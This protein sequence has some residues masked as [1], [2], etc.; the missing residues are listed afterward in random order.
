MV[1]ASGRSPDPLRIGDHHGMSLRSVSMLF[2]VALLAFASSSC[3]D[4]GRL[5]DRQPDVTGVVAGTDQ[6]AGP[7]L[8]EPSDSYFERMSLVR[9]DPVLVKSSAGESVPFSELE[10]GDEVEVWIDGA[11]AESYP[12]Q[13]GIVALRL[14]D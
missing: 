8:T 11:C 14:R 5:P 9:G 12:V 10:D 7:V 6:P 2:G 1:L 13:C 4:A 3:G